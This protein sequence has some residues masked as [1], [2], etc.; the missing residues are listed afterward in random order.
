MANGNRTPRTRMRRIELLTWTAGGS[1]TL[2]FMRTHK[3]QKPLARLHFRFAFQVTGVGGA[4][5]LKKDASV[6]LLANRVEITAH[7]KELGQITIMDLSG[8]SLGQFWHMTNDLIGKEQDFSDPTPG[9]A[10]NADGRRELVVCLDSPYARARFGS[11]IDPRD[12]SNFQVKIVFGAPSDYASANVPTVQL[13]TIA[14]HVEE[15][16]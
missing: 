14:V 5:T 4:A 15:I 8:D 9:A 11:R 1:A 6:A 7:H 12:L 16:L 3:L 10:A 13:A 2:D